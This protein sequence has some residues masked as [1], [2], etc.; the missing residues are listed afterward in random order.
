MSESWDD[1][2]D[3]WDTNEAV[4]SYSKK[5]YQSL[6]NVVDLKGRKVLDFG[7]GTGLLT[8]KVSDQASLVVAIDPPEKMISVLT[9]KCLSNVHAIANG[10]TQE[11]IGNNEELLSGFDIIVA[12]SSLA[13]VPD[14][15][16]TLKLLRSLLKTG[17]LLIQ[18]DWLAEDEESRAGFSRKIIENVMKQAGFSKISTSVPF[19]MESTDSSMKV[20][21]GVAENVR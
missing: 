11:L 2:A 17:G 13:F 16:K 21:M 5:A 10:L 8:E 4:V 14:Y 19:S 18:W 3:G 9:G 7:C 12:S 6:L 1:Y 20:V 15:Q